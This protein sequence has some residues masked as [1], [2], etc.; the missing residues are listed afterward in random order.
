MK[1]FRRL[2]VEFIRPYWPRVL[3]AS[4][5]MSLLTISW[6]PIMLL[7]KMLFD[8]V[9]PQK[10]G[11]LL[12]IILLGFLCIYLFRSMVTFALQYTVSFLGQRVVYHLRR[13]L[14]DKLGQLQLS[15]Y[16][17]R[18]TGKIM[19]RV[20][21]DVSA[22][23]NLV[24]GGF[25]T[26]FTDAIMVFA[27]IG[28]QFYLSWQLT[29]ASIIVLPMYAVNYSFFVKQIREVNKKIREKISEMYGLL[30]ER[31]SAVRLVRSFA[32]EEYEINRFREK[33][34]D[35]YQ[36][37]IKN[38]KLNTSLG[39][40]AAIISGLGTVI[41]LS[42][43]GLMLKEKQMTVGSFV[44]FQSSLIYLYGPIVRLTQVNT[45]I[46]WVM[47]SINRIFEVLDEPVLITDRD[48]AID[49]GKFIGHIEFNHVGFRYSLSESDVL[50]AID[51]NI[52]PGTVVGIV[53][54]S[55]S[56]KSTFLSL[57]VRLYDVGSGSIRIDGH[58]IQDVRLSSLRRHIGYVP[59]ESFLFSGT[60]RSNILY[61]RMDATE[62]EMIDASIA[63][64]IHEYIF[65]LPDKYDTVIGER[66]ITLSG[67]QKQRIALARALLTKPGVLLLDDCTSSLDA[68]T[69]SRIQKTLEKLL[70]G[71]SSFIVAHRL[72]SVMHAD[73]IIVLEN[74]RMAQKGTHNDLVNQEGFYARLFEEQYSSILENTH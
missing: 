34:N 32:K 58:D 7:T 63:A 13:K 68:E 19:A 45:I 28:V 51:L 69:E 33:V 20:M 1:N 36:L 9:I 40:V 18:L 73:L 12:I 53:G 22:V 48:N 60:I 56:G 41:F 42:V 49:L 10:D 21:N 23:Q 64:E 38:S 67:G 72:S 44:A 46:Q 2:I 24:T 4:L 17:Q 50:T 29:L 6:V 26:M 71:R 16:D 30:A 37:N 39:S 47:V 31:V 3:Y 52:R 27:V 62:K 8:E 14:H 57:M 59:Q 66:G 11:K 65:A 5:F 61:G 70:E 15:Y 25:I 43:G 35:N 55:G 54:P 74:G